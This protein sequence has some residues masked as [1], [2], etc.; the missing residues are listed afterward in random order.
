M[1]RKFQEYK[2]C[3]IEF[4]DE[5][6]I[7]TVIDSSIIVPM[8]PKRGYSRTKEKQKWKKEIEEEFER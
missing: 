8:E 5:L 6:E 2:A 7:H 1:N 4:V 3:T